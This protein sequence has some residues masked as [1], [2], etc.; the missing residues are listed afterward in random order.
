MGLDFGHSNSI[1]LKPQEMAGYLN[2]SLKK[3]YRL[4]EDRTIPFYKIGRSLRFKKEDVE[5]YLEKALV[6]SMPEK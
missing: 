6:K 5:A 2:V 4:V 1:F 3:I